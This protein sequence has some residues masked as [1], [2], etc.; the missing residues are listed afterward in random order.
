MG[1]PIIGICAATE[2]ASWG[3]W[4]TPAHLLP[5]EYALAVQRAGGLALLLPSDPRADDDPG[6]WLD[7]LDGLLLAG[8]CDID[9]ASYGTDVRH[10]TVD[11]TDVARDRFEI[12]LARAA[13][14]R[15]LPLL[16]ICRGMQLLNVARGGTL[17][18]HLEQGEHRRALG[19]FDGNDHEV[20]LDADSLAA[21]SAGER[22]HRVLSHHHQAVDAL[23]EGLVVT[24]RAT[25]GL[26]EAVE[27]PG[28]WALGVQWHPEADETSRLVS[29][30]VRRA[31]DARAHGAP[32]PS[33]PLG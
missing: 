15:E 28:T 30:L 20:L 5:R 1:F 27:V 7:L 23:G 11:A 13:L 12:A 19:T 2:L 3:V 18:Q 9:P 31:G 17:V 29:A 33:T 8:G 22:R 10:P 32:A 24:G 25:D 21:V 6:P 26:V 4:H 14:A 16:G